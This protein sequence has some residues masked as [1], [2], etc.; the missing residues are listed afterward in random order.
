MSTADKLAMKRAADARRLA[1]GAPPP[2]PAFRRVGGRWNSGALD[3]ERANEALGTGGSEK[4]IDTKKKAPSTA[5]KSATAETETAET[6]RVEREKAADF[7]AR[8]DR[9]VAGVRASLDARGASFE[10]FANVS[11]RFK[12]GGLSG[13][14]YLAKVTAMGLE[15]EHV[16]ELASLMPDEKLRLE[17][18]RAI[19]AGERAR[20]RK[21]GGGDASVDAAAALLFGGNA[22]KGRDD[23]KSSVAS[24]SKTWDCPSCTFR[25]QAASA[26]CDVCD[27]ARGGG[28]ARGDG[29]GASGPA[30]GGGGGGKGGKGKKKARGAKISLTAVGGTGVGGLDAFIP[31]REKAVWG[32]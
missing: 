29:A 26:R 16:K 25:N 23:D 12:E 27:G 13:A 5:A 17:L 2:E 1:P 19:A 20:A 31:G 18:R 21:E 28:A 3:L 10:V 6:A 32:A 30:P 22:E 7:A 9:L 11:S 15:T 14:A 4:G 24:S 8:N